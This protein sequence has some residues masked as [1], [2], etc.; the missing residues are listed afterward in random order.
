MKG[1]IRMAIVLDT[2]ILMNNPENLLKNVDEQLIVP[3]IVVEELD[4]L[5]TNSDSK[6]AFEARQ[7][8][9][10]LRDNEGKYKFIK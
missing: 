3:S 6:K 10:Y 2:N 4:H 9:R 7:G 8:M 5:K 1:R